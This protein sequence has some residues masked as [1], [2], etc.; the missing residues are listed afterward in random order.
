MSYEVTTNIK[1]PFDWLSEVA[2][3]WIGERTNR[4]VYQKL[5]DIYFCLV[6]GIDPNNVK[7]LEGKTVEELKEEYQKSFQ[8]MLIEALSSIVED[9]KNETLKFKV[10]FE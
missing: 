8:P 10:E 4:Q 1:T 2:W 6:D 7:G 5:D 3:E 9:L